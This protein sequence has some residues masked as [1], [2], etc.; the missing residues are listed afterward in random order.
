MA[1]RNDSVP[2][3]SVELVFEF[4]QIRNFSTIHLHT[5]NFFSRNVQVKAIS[6][7]DK[8]KTIGT[9][10]NDFVVPIE[11]SFLVCTTKIQNLILIFKRL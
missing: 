5:N 8:H 11:N 7:T 9:N 1:W 2:N 4:D 6:S 10:A 3:G